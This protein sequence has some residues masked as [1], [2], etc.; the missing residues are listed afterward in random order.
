[1]KIGLFERK[2]PNQPVEDIDG[3]GVVKV[4]G[5]PDGSIQKSRKFAEGH[6]KIDWK[7]RRVNLKKNDILNMWGKKFLSFIKYRLSLEGF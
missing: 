6:C 4:I 1:M 7:S 2:I 5:I 3:E